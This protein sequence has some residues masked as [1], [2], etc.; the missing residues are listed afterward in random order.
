MQT[1][2][3]LAPYQAHTQRIREEIK[4]L[5]ESGANMLLPSE[6]IEVFSEFH[7]P[8]IDQVFLSTKVDNG[9]IYEDPQKKGHFRISAQGMEKLANC[10][11]IAWDPDKTG[12]IDRESD[13]M[14]FQAVGSIRQPDGTLSRPMVGH[15]HKDLEVI[16]EDLRDQYRKKGSADKKTGAELERYVEFCTTRDMRQERRHLLSKCETGAKCRVI[17]KLLNLKAGY[18]RAELEKPFVIVRIEFRP[19]YNDPDVKKFL[20]LA[21]VQAAT[22]LFGAQRPLLAPAPIDVTPPEPVEPHPE[23]E[24]EDEDP[25]PNGPEARR[26]DFEN[27]DKEAQEQTL[28]L[29]ARRKA[30]DLKDLEKRLG[31]SLDKFPAEK[32]IGLFDHLAAMPAGEDD[33]P[34]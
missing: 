12:R 9:D 19:N 15:Y 24:P 10:A 8:V 3:Q 17:K 14:S 22:G 13:Y 20:L 7:M 32:R 11:Q 23:P 28:R 29:L 16:E 25:D 4:K 27:S 26:I 2:D 5:K 6:R 33:I 34:F 21:G 1:A 31:Y 18:T 30:Y